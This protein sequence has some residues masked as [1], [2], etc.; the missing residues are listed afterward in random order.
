MISFKTHDRMKIGTPI[1]KVKTISRVLDFYQKDLELQ[2]NNKKYDDSSPVYVYELG[3]KNLPS[4]D[5]NILPL[6]SGY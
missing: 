3:F 2:V 4:S 6:L 1:I 5:T